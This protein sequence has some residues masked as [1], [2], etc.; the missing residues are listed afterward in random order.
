[1]LLGKRLLQYCVH[2]AL[3]TLAVRLYTELIQSVENAT[4]LRPSVSAV[5]LQPCG[6]FEVG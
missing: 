5:G 2:I 6:F 3:D 1:M 4:S